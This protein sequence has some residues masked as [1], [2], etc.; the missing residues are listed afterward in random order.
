M[1]F[2]SGIESITYIQRVEGNLNVQA[3]NTIAI[4]FTNNTQRIVYPPLPSNA[5]EFT[6]ATSP[7]YKDLFLNGSSVVK[8]LNGTVAFMN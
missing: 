2:T 3:N 1:N 5:S 6:R 4:A 8:F 7:E